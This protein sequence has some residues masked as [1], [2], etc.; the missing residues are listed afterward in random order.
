MLLKEIYLTMRIEILI[1]LFCSLLLEIEN[2]LMEYK[3]F[4]KPVH[5]MYKKIKNYFIKY[6]YNR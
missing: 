6:F 4:I 5:K 3:C 1:F 2:Y